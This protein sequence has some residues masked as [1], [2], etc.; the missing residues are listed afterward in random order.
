MKRLL[1]GALLVASFQTTADITDFDEWSINGYGSFRVGYTNSEGENLNLLKFYPE[2]GKAFADVE[3]LLGVQIQIPIT[4]KLKAVTQIATLGV[5]DFELNTEWFYLKYEVNQNYGIKVGKMAIPL[6]YHSQTEFIGYLHNFGRLP[7]SV[8]IGHEF[9]VLTGIGL[10]TKHFVGDGFLRTQ[11]NYGKW[12]GDIFQSVT[13]EFAPSSLDDIF[14]ANIE[15]TVD[16]WTLFAGYLTG[17]FKSQTLDEGIVDF[18]EP[19]AQSVGLTVDQIS[20]LFPYLFVTDKKA[21]YT[22]AGAVYQYKDWTFSSEVSHYGIDDSLD[23]FNFAWYL[24]VGNQFNDHVVTVHV[25]QMQQPPQG[26]SQLSGAPD[27][28]QPIGEFAIDL[29]ARREFKAVGITWRYE[30]TSNIALKIDFTQGLEERQEIGRYQYGAIGV[31]F[32]F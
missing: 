4:D 12:D 3:S 11:L 28:L 16:Q 18:A 7:K 26:Y 1:F 15:Y 24:A 23:S 22:F 5:N 31:D 8:Y 30:L 6:F 9:N 19:I 21:Q 14:T 20:P 27:A 29:F 10:N 32:I 2:N 17:R 25:E 13:N